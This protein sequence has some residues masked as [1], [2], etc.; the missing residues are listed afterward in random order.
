MGGGRGGRLCPAQMVT[1]PPG[2]PDNGSRTVWVI[3][4]GSPEDDDGRGGSGDEQVRAL[5]DDAHGGPGSHLHP[6]TVAAVHDAAFHLNLEH[7]RQGG[8]TR[9]TGQDDLRGGRS[10]DSGRKLGHLNAPLAPTAAPSAAPRRSVISNP[11]QSPSPGKQPTVC[12]VEAEWLKPVRMGAFAHR[13]WRAHGA[14]DRA[15]PSVTWPCL[16][17]V[18]MPNLLHRQGVC[19]SVR[20]LG[21]HW[22]LPSNYIST[23]M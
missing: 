13:I 5:G 1:Q 3:G 7:R 17:T 8:I 23:P 18:Q 12:P 9:G 2:S 4:L 10:S 11:S 20:G 16:L 22:R 15:T 21:R 6:H 14:G 19:P